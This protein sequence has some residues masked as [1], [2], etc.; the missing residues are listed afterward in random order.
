MQ[1]I[2]VGEIDVEQKVDGIVRVLD[3][4]SVKVAGLIDGIGIGKVDMEQEMD[5]IVDFLNAVSVHVA[6][7]GGNA[8]DGLPEIAM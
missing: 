3:S 1:R 8:K 6:V 5:R 4:V 7:L 2:A